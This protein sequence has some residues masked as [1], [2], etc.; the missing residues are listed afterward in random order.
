MSRLDLMTNSSNESRI[1]RARK[2]FSFYLLA[3]DINTDRSPFFRWLSIGILVV[4][5]LLLETT[6]FSSWKVFD[7]SPTF[8]YVA[9]AAVA[10]YCG[11]NTGMVFGFFAGLGSDFFYSTPIGISALSMLICAIIVGVAQTGMMRPTPLAIPL[12]TFIISFTGNT[13]YVLFSIMVGFEELFSLHSAYL[14]VV[15]S[16]LNVIASPFIFAITKNFIGAP[17]WKNR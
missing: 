15:S 14:I 6:V 2:N 8:G 7:S 1:G 11:A 12:L 17:A 9:T 13:L 5:G 3:A 10:Y 4:L 16:L